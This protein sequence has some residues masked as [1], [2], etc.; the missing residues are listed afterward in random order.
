MINHA[1]GSVNWPRRSRSERRFEVGGHRKSNTRTSHRHQTG[2]QSPRL[3]LPT[4]STNVLSSCFLGSHRREAAW[5]KEASQLGGEQWEDFYFFHVCLSDGDMLS[6]LFFC[7][8]SS[9]R[10]RFIFSSTNYHMER[11]KLQQLQEQIIT[12]GNKQTED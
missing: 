5:K 7:F 2:T 12:G 1:G 10:E 4:S 8:F 3:K 6:P 9:L 11:K